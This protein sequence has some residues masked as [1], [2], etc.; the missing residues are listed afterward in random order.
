MPA[1]S[2]RN[3]EVISGTVIVTA[4][5]ATAR[6][7]TPSSRNC[8]SYVPGGSGRRNVIATG[9][10]ASAPRSTSAGMRNAS[11]FAPFGVVHDA[12]ERERDDSRRAR[13]SPQVGSRDRQD[14]LDGRL[15]RPSCR[16]TARA[17]RG[18]RKRRGRR[19]GSSGRPPEGPAARAADPA[20]ARRTGARTSLFRIPPSYAVFLKRHIPRPEATRCKFL[21]AAPPLS[22]S[23]SRSGPRPRP[24]RRL[25]RP[26]PTRISTRPPRAGQEVSRKIW[27]YAETALKETKSAALLEDVAREGRL[28]RDARRR[29]ECRRPSSRPRGPARRS[30]RSSPSTTPCPASRR[31]RARRRS[32]P[33]S[34]GAPGQGCGHNLLGTAAVAAAVAANRERVAQKLPGTIRVYGTPAEELILG[35][36][37]MLQGR[38][39]RGHG[40][41]PRLAPGG[42]ET[43]STPASAS[44]S[45]PSTSSSSARRRTRRRTP[46][47]AAALSTPSRS[48]TTRCRSCASTSCRRRASTAS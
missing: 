30:S 36:T 41:R 29:R 33:P 5:V 15:R 37:F 16:G 20:R 2:A 10:D 48:S 19:S 38:R 3:S 46:G 8:T 13:G 1:S 39:L 28:R 11:T 44:R 26:A 14:E 9:F 45:R 12:R 34:P 31:R 42:P 25:S 6:P 23:A 4:R 40:R 17:P 47:W 22:L 7:A 35:K 18:A 21:S 43:T 24:R 32:P 27:D